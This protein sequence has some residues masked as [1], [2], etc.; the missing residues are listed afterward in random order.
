MELVKEALEA[1]APVDQL[2]E[3]CTYKSR[4]RGMYFIKSVF[5]AFALAIIIELLMYYRLAMHDINVL[6]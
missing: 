4:K 2:A 6:T 3:V 5:A 1:H